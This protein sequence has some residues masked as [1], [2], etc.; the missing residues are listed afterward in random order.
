MGGEET[1]AVILKT[2]Q[3][4]GRAHALERFLLFNPSMNFSRNDIVAFL[5]VA[6]T[7]SVSRA[8]DHVGLTQPSVSKAVKRLEEELGVSLFQRGTHGARLTSEG[9][10]FLE[11][12]KRYEAQH[13]ELVRTASEMRAQHSGLL[14]IGMTSPAAD[15]LAVRAIAEMVRRRPATRLQLTFGKSDALNAA[16]EDGEIDLALV[17]TYP[18][19]SLSCSKVDIAED[20]T[21]I[22][23]RAS[24]P[25]TQLPLV[26]ISDLLSYGWVM[27]SPKSVARRHVFQIFEKNGVAAPHVGIEAEYISEAIMGVLMGTDLL[28]MVPTSVLRGWLGR[29]QPLPV[30]ELEI[31]RTVVLLFN[32]QAKWTPLMNAFRDLLLDMRPQSLE[33]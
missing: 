27:P 7:G 4:Q 12:A 24:H 3:A 1:G 23:V 21:H 32:P 9:Q 29:V 16:V 25:L 31:R 14:R 6:R 2:M 18:G 13:F 26:S 30:P 8:A 22:V 5:E 10:F 15:G 17:P 20:H 28:A 33:T 11:S 19:H